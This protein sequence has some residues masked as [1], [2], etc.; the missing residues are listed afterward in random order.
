MDPLKLADAAFAVMRVVSQAVPAAIMRGVSVG[1]LHQE[2]AVQVTWNGEPVE[3]DDDQARAAAHDKA[4]VVGHRIAE[5]LVGEGYT[6]T[7]AVYVIRSTPTHAT[8][9]VLVKVAL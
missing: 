5:A 3:A 2:T 6:L 4:D 9:G 1:P 7:E 8:Y